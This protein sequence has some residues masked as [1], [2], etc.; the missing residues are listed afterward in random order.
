MTTLMSCSMREQ[1]SHRSD[2]NGAQ[3]RV[4]FGALARVEASCGLIE[5]EQHGIGAHGARDLEAALVAIGQVAGGIVGARG[6]ARSAR[7]SAA[8]FRRRRFSDLRQLLV[9]RRPRKTEK[10]DARISAIVLGDDEIFEHRHALETAGCSGT[11][12]RRGPWPRSRS[13][14]CAPAG[15][16]RLTIVSRD[17]R[18]ESVIASTS[19]GVGDAGAREREATFRRLVEAGDA[20]EYGRLAGAVG[21]DQRGD[22]ATPDGE[23]QIVDGDEPAEA[24][25]EMLDDKQRVRFASAEGIS[26]G[27]P[28]RA[29]RKRPCAGAGRSTVLASR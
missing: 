6:E 12:A 7:A 2:A 11:C 23:R 29:S 27:P 5:T 15:R 28:S 17:G 16:H 1:T 14:A 19:S 22:V 8:P 13:P 20:V 18:V 10:P 4:E 21:A 26:R 24:H 25:R 3:Q 9:P